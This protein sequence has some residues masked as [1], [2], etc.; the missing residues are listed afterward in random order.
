M[1]ADVVVVGAGVI[2]LSTAVRLQEQGAR[3]LVLTADRPDAT[4]S[5][6]AAAVWYPTGMPA[7]ARNAEWSAATFDELARQAADGVPGVTMDPCRMLTPRAA[8]DL[9]WWAAAVPG[10]RRLAAAEATGGWTAGWAFRAPTVEMP[11]YLP[12]L[13]DRFLHA[14]GTLVHRRLSGLAEAARWAPAVVNATGL[15]AARLCGD[16]GLYPVR[17]QL[18]VTTNPGLRTSVRVQDHP[19]GYTY[20]HPRSRDVVLGGTF[21]I[22][23]ADTTV[24]PAT[25]RAIVAR[26]TALVPQ[27]AEAEILAHTVGLRPA[28]TGGV[29]LEADDRSLPGHR[30]V[31]NYGHG[32]AG[33]TFSWGCADDAAALVAAAVH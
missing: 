18:V 5:A 23:S 3:V 15:G 29:R 1:N 30:V 9:P 6:V 27:L 31:H 10:F 4:T 2:G 25:A 33:V 22:G 32:G 14:G 7:T 8:D 24:D 12:W 21:E 11:V 19:D 16:P 28:R 13:T 20:V 17:G 26:C